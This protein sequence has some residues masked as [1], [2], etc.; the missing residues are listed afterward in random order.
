MAV[1]RNAIGRGG[2]SLDSRVNA[3]LVGGPLLMAALAR[4]EIGLRGELLKEAVRDGGEVIVDAWKAKVPVL[5]RNYQDGIGVQARATKGGATGIVGVGPIRGLPRNEQPRW[6]A[7]RLEYGDK[8]GPRP[9]GAQPSARP[10]FDTSKQRAGDAIE[11]KLRDLIG[12]AT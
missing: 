2:K 12:R 5:D 8:R 7:A 3:T 10:A 11:A 9:R 1:L 4:L 6:Y